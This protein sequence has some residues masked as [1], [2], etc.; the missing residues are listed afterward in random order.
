MRTQDILTRVNEAIA[1]F[2]DHCSPR[3]TLDALRGDLEAQIRTEIANSKGVGNA[4]KVIEKILAVTK[5]DNRKNLAYPWIDA[6]GR[7]CVCNGYVAYRLKN[8]LPL[9]E[10]PEE[11]GDG[12]DL[13]RIFPAS[14]QGWKPLPMPSV[15]ELREFIAIERTKYTG[16]RRSNFEP[17]WD[18]GP[19]APNVNALFLL[20]AATIF[21]NADTI[22]WNTLVRPLVITCDSG[23]GVILPL[24]SS[25]EKVPEPP[26]SDDERKAIEAQEAKDEQNR[27]ESQER[28]RIITQA[29]KDFDEAQEALRAALIAQAAAKDSLAK[30]TSEAEK[31]TY[32][33][34][35]YNASETLAKATLRKYAARLIFDPL[36]CI[37]PEQFE[38]VVH[39]LHVREYAKH[40][41]A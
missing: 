34:A 22:F 19:H 14:L 24:R 1:L 12:I 2:D 31:A 3:E 6:Q 10:R 7:Q 38:N 33:E 27:Q 36:F 4:V 40:N 30:A 32:T 25:A 17:A 29:H 20:D 13:D 21:P 26:A 8:H 35:Y 11:V 23:D 39:D 15:K 5:K 28:H 9:P 37:E 41:A 18:F 16:R